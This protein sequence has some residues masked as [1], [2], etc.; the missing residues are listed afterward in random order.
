M[1]CALR[2]LCVCFGKDTDM[3]LKTDTDTDSNKDD[4]V[5]RTHAVCYL[6]CLLLM[7]RAVL[8]AGALRQL[9]GG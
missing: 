7:L 1:C 3:D 2:P 9:P 4:V 8:P 6:L 5:Q